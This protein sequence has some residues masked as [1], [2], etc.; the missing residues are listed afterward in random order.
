MKVLRQINKSREGND[1]WIDETYALCEWL[2]V[3]Y[4]LYH[5]K[6]TGW[7]SSEEVRVV[8]EPTRDKEEIEKQWKRLIKEKL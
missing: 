6:V 8:N 2:D 1:C 4:I 3:Y 7:N 5:W